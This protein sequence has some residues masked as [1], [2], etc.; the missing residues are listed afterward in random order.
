M[1]NVLA[2]MAALGIQLDDHQPDARL[3]AHIEATRA[4]REQN[5]NRSSPLT[6]LAR[7]IGLEP[8]RTTIEPATC[9][10]AA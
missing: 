8:I 9:A 3:L 10:C 1:N 6:R 2:W 5:R 4:A 7:R